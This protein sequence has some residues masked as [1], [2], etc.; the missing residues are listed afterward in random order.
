MP[1]VAGCALLD[2]PAIRYSAVHIGPVY[3]DLSRK[4]TPQVVDGFV[5]LLNMDAHEALAVLASGKPPA[6]ALQ[7]AG[8]H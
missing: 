3:E 4:V 2:R 5:E 6:S 1:Q 8:W 7:Q